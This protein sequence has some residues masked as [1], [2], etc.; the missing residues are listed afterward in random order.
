MVHVIQ[1]KIIS[2]KNERYDVEL[3]IGGAIVNKFY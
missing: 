3:R 2:K 1:H